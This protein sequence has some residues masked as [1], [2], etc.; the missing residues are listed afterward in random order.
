MPTRFSQ[1]R[2]RLRT[3]LIEQRLCLFQVGRVKALGELAID[4][5]EQGARV[6]RP[7][8][9]LPEPG[10]ARGGSQLPRPGLTLAGQ[11]QGLLE[12]GLSFLDTRGW[13]RLPRAVLRQQE[14]SPQPMDLGF[15]RT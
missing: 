6:P 7:A 1:N 2:S 13:G 10:E 3:E 12:T 5:R 8:L 14:C 15:P 11:A 4:R 9:L